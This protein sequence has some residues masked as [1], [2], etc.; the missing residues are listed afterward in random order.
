M[1]AY[2]SKNQE[3]IVKNYQFKDA[4]EEIKAKYKNIHVVKKGETITGKYVASFTSQKTGFVNHIVEVKE[5]KAVIAGNTILNSFFEDLK[6][7]KDKSFAV[8]FLGRGPRK[9]GKQP[10]YLFDL[11][12]NGEEDQD[13]EP[14]DLSS[15]EEEVNN[16]D[17]L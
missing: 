17:L 11:S 1:K 10:A 8:K 5:G 12:W 16:D 7:Q 13:Q 14:Q 9:Q 6:L 15:A 2:K 3:P 4:P